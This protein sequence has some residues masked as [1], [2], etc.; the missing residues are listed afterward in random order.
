MDAPRDS[1]VRAAARTVVAACSVVL[2]AAVCSVVGAPVDAAAQGVAGSGGGAGS[3]AGTDPVAP[4]RVVLVGDSIMLGAAP[5]L[6]ASLAAAG[7]APV[8]DAAESRSTSKGAEHVRLHAAAGADAL[9]VML[10]ANDAGNPET[11]RGRV[12]EVVAAAEGIEHLYWLTIPEVRDYYPEANRI[13]AE[14]MA[15]RE[16]G[17]VLDWNS[18]LSAGGLTSGDGMHLTPDGA[19]A[20][21]AMVVGKLVEGLLAPPEPATTTTTAAAP[22]ADEDLAGDAPAAGGGLVEEVERE[23]T[24]LASEPDPVE[25]ASGPGGVASAI[26]LAAVVLFSSGIGVAL[27]ALWNTRRI[28]QT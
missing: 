10:G 17:E 27:W 12:A 19:E 28:R 15:V 18:A 24:E 25:N 4:P 20:M 7:F 6:E 3:A 16:G 8:V 5:A 21:A 23:V 9:V 11:Y 1:S 26:V 13:I 22:G 2:A 14:A